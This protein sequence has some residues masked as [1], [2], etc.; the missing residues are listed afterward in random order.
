M[1]HIG[2]LSTQAAVAVAAEGI[3]TE[4]R[5]GTARGCGATAAVAMMRR[6]VIHKG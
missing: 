3:A 6:E 2:C 1:P 5:S 4:V